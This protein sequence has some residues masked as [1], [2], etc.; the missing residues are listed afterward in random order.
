MTQGS[1]GA[2]KPGSSAKLNSAAAWAN[3]ASVLGGRLCNQLVLG[4][5][6]IGLATRKG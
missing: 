5:D 4:A 3:T 1:G 6:G 2:S